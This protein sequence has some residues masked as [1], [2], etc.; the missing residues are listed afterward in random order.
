MKATIKIEVNTIDEHPP[1][2]LDGMPA[3]VIDDDGAHWNCTWCEDESQFVCE[4]AFRF[5][6]P[7]PGAKYWFWQIDVEEVQ[8]AMKNVH[9]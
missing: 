5:G 3:T 7:I 1:K 2:E 9:G 4:E 8:Q 6:Y